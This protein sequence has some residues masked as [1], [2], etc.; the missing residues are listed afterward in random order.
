MI[1]YKVILQISVLTILNTHLL[2]ASKK[3]TL[4]S[5]KNL[6]LFTNIY[7]NKKNYYHYLY[8]R[9]DVLKGDNSTDENEGINEY[10]HDFLKCKIIHGRDST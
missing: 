3:F 6:L 9:D 7:F 5:T 4:C 10:G 1:K 8:K 2:T